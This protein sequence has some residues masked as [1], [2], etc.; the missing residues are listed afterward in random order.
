MKGSDD[1][2][3]SEYQQIS[4]ELQNSKE[5]VADLMR[6]LEDLAV[7]YEQKAEALGGS[8]FDLCLV[9]FWFFHFHEKS[10]FA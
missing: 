7:S 5:E 8:V 1:R 3:S 9:Y 2:N 6:A 10:L 4:Q